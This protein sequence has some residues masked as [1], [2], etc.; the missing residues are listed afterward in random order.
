ML[1]A[2]DTVIYTFN[3]DI[4]QIQNTLQSQLQ[5]KA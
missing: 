5:V 1:Y 4:L 3:S 2:D